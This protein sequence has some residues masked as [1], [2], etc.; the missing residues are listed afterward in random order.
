MKKLFA[1]LALVAV[2]TSC[3][4]KKKEPK[5]DV[6][7]PSTTETITP[8]S[9]AA[10]TTGDVPKFSDPDVQKYANDY[11][12]FVNGYV[13]A[14]KSKDMSKIA[15]LATSASEWGTKSTAMFTKLA[16]SPEEATKL[17]TYMSKLANDMVVA[18]KAM[19][20]GTK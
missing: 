17:T 15:S 12:A 13:E 18:A 1:V 7:V 16:T 3:K 6:P 2:M 8:S 20:P 14:Y 10:T 9:D 4:D 5:I 19:M 11:T